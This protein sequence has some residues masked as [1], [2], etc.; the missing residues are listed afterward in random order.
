MM[1]KPFKTVAFSLVLGAVGVVGLA[2]A[3][4]CSSGG[5]CGDKGKCS[6]DPAPTQQSIDLCNK[7]E[8]AA[9]GSQYKDFAS[10]ASGQQ[11]CKSDNTTDTT[12]TTNNITANCATQ[13]TAYTTCCTSNATACQ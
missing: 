7:I 9:C 5:G 10:C 4:A 2:S 3:P 6:A 13:L 8:A 11:A 12:A 1:I